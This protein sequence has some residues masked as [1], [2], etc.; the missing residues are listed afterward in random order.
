M[1]LSYLFL[2]VALI[3]LLN[4]SIRAQ[5]ILAPGEEKEF[6]DQSA[7]AG[8]AGNNGNFLFTLNSAYDVNSKIIKAEASGIAIGTGE[9]YAL[10]YYD[11]QISET[12]E[13]H[14]N[15]VGAW[16]SY[17]VLWIGYQE[18][19]ASLGSNSYVNVEV[20]LRDVT[21]NNVIK[22][23]TV[24]DLDLKTHSFKVI[25]GGFNFHDSGDQTNIFSALFIRGHSYRL[26]V[27]LTATLFITIPSSLI[28][29]CDYMDGF[30]GG[31]DGRAEL[32][33]LFVKVALDDK[34]TAMKL[35]RIDSLNTRI[36][37]LEYKLSHHYHIY[38]TGRGVGQ[39]NTQANTT[40]SI[41]E[42][43]GIT[44]TSTPI[45]EETPGENIPENNFE[46]K[47]VPDKFS[48]EQN[49]PNPFNPSTKISFAIPTQS[50]VTIKVY[51]ILGRQVK[52]L[53]NET[54]SPGYYEINFNAATLPS[55]TY[56]YEIRAGNP[57]SGSGQSF[58]E[59]KKM[60]LLK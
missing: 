30:L 48:L 20:I 50:F 25:I 16:I 38:L 8:D 34:E 52:T 2:Y 28:S 17:D 1:K 5:I 57:S 42:E 13:T 6:T 56:I 14:N 18:I 44:G 22:T 47:S 60:I 21:E 55:G 26:G 59:T 40:L 23:E 19:L 46:N 43:G 45:Y 39:N 11:F 41:F 37:S 36:D 27:K 33:K 29:Y 9:A 49:Y 51:D 4:I 31:G 32:T 15:T 54:K 12:P 24:H 35:A 53:M 3:I 7:T 10:I 58:V